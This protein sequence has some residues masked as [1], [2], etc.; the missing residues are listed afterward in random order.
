MISTDK[1]RREILHLNSNHVP[2]LLAAGMLLFSSDFFFFFYTG[3]R[4]VVSFSIQNK[5]AALKS[6]N[7]NIIPNS[8]CIRILLIVNWY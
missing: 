5:V 6:L 1:G 8:Y 7:W 3:S 2:K 4:H